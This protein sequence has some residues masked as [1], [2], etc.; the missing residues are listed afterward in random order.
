MH[1]Q[2]MDMRLICTSVSE[3]VWIICCFVR[4]SYG[5]GIVTQSVR[6]ADISHELLSCNETILQVAIERS[7]ACIAHLDRVDYHHERCR[8]NDASCRLGVLA[9]HRTSVLA[10]A[11]I[12]PEHSPYHIGLVVVG[13]VYSFSVSPIA[14]S[15]SCLTKRYSYPV[16][17][18]ARKYDPR[19]CLIYASHPG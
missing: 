10:M 1:K 3:N 7:R 15:P 5:I 9:L 13:L 17:F 14:T 19:F 4:R 16:P 12:C 11:P 8:S 18:N 2:C 6:S